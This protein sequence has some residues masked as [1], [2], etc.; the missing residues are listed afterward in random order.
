MNRNKFA[1][2]AIIV[3]MIV[4]ALALTWHSSHA[5]QVAS[6]AQSIGGNAWLA[7]TPDTY[8]TICLPKNWRSDPRSQQLLADTAKPNFARLRQAGATKIYVEGNADFEH[9][10]HS[11]V[12][13]LP[14]VCA[15]DGDG[16]TYKWSG[17]NVKYAE[18]QMD[19]C[20]RKLLNRP[21]PDKP[22]P[23]IDPKP[24][25]K[26]GPELPDVNPMQPAVLAS[27]IDPVKMILV[28]AACGIG[29]WAV[30]FRRG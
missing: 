8:L 4:G 15:Q 3:A 21:K 19:G 9:R 24:E 27:D 1:V 18:S 25:P 13:S 29:A 28:C 16:T 22:E 17:D 23:K 26:N 5:P 2:A 14:A 12:G 6:V 20:I 7:G 10:F 11:A 30:V